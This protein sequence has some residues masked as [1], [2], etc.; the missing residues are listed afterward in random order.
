[1][2]NSNISAWGVAGPDSVPFKLHLVVGSSG[3]VR[4]NEELLVLVYPG[5]LLQI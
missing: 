3:G 4:L 1:M 5:Y 2:K